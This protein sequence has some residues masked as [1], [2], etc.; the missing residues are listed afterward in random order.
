MNRFLEALR[1]RRQDFKALGAVATDH[2]TLAGE[3]AYT[4]VLLDTQAEEL[5][6]K[7]LAGTLESAEAAKLRGHLLVEMAGM[8]C[9][10]GL[11]MQLHAGVF[12]NH[13][14]ELMQRFGPDKGGDIPVALELTRA[15]R[16]LLQAH[17]N[18]PKLRLVVFVLD[19]TVYTRELA[20][21]AGV[22]PALQVG[23]PWWFHDSR[24]GMRRYLEQLT[25]TAGIQN[26][27][28]FNDDARALPSI[29]V[30]HQLW[31]RAVCDWAAQM[32]TQHLM[33]EPEALKAV[34]DLSVGRAAHVY[35]LPVP[36]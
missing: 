29:A 6:Q 34:F 10:D 15:L 32:L 35:R 8:S 12:R 2:G 17:G 28:G 30:R 11:V 16:P 27:A 1:K 14:D 19:E 25:E 24:N 7:A 22:Y 3:G 31:R 5:F 36:V 13:N 21:L 20:P 23:A 26:L 9:E 18:N 4:V 33:T